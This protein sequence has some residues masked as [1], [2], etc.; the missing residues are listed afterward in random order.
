MINSS[1]ELIVKSL[2]LSHNSENIFDW[3]VWFVYDN[4]NKDADIIFQG[5]YCDMRRIYNANRKWVKK[6]QPEYFELLEIMKEDK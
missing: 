2:E 4:D 5:S 6:V 3:Y 1:N